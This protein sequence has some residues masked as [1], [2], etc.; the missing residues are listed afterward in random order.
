MHLAVVWPAVFGLTYYPTNCVKISIGSVC[1]LFLAVCQ[2]LVSVEKSGKQAVTLMS[3]DGHALAILRDP[4]IYP[5]RK[6]EIVTRLVASLYTYQLMTAPTP[7]AV[8]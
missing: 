1:L 5:N 2:C 6:E 3:K 4:E 8:A 7:A